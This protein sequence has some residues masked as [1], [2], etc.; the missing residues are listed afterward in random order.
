[1]QTAAQQQQASNVLLFNTVTA[2]TDEA[3]RA[4]FKSGAKMYRVPPGCSDSKCAVELTQ[5]EVTKL[6]TSQDGKLHIANNGI[7]NDV[8]GAI[9]YAQ[10]HGNT[11]NADGTTNRSD[12]PANQYVIYAQQTNNF[13]SE[14]MV[15]GYQK[16]GS[17]GGLTEAEKVNLQVMQQAATNKQT[18]VI[19]SHSRGTL[20]TT[21][22]QQQ[23]LNT[24]GNGTGPAIQM[25]NYGS[26][27]D[28]QTGNSVLQKV[29]GNSNA[30]INAIIH[31]QDTIG[32]GTII[33]NNNPTGSYTST[34]NGQATTTTPKTTDQGWFSNFW[35]VLTGTATPHNCYGTSGAR[36][37][38]TIIWNNIPASNAPTNVPNNP[39]PPS[40]QNN[41]PIT[42]PANLQQQQLQQ[43]VQS[44]SNQQMQ[45]IIRINNSTPPQTPSGGTN[46]N[47][48]SRLLFLNQFL[49]GQ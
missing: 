47:T 8:D 2:F 15:A 23:L 13:I 42:N 21:N 41:S 43:Q 22:A 39:N 28:L 16:T 9:K 32:T 4:M 18:L 10:E 27:Q 34:N 26:A 24:S 19:D 45:S 20:T 1:L 49:N 17:L 14:L 48:D 12:K 25:N 6:K 37:D 11:V 7:F 5:D 38:C 33:G 40:T 36:P 3:Y 44:Q 31:P 30:T 46:G 29:T 35:N